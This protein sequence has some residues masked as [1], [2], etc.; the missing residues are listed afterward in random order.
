LKMK[1][2]MAFLLAFLAGGNFF[3]LRG[4]S[5]KEVIKGAIVQSLPRVDSPFLRG[6]GFSGHNVV[7]ANNTPFFCRLFAGGKELG[8]LGPGS[9]AFDQRV[10]QNMPYQQI[11]IAALCFW[12]ENLSS[13]AGAAG[14]IIALYGYGYNQAVQWVIR[15]YDVKSPDGKVFSDLPSP[16]GIVQSRKVRLPRE[17]WNATLGLQVVNNTRFTARIFINGV[18]AGAIDTSGIAHYTAKNLSPYYGRQ[19]NLTVIF[20]N[21]GEVVGTYSETLYVPTYGVWSRQII[22]G[23]E[24]ARRY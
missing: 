20:E 13:Y 24:H 15:T 21:N 12:D 14:Q 10:W 3:P 18:S 1:K 8:T 11:P 17:W 4:Q 2:T 23:P 9:L 16:R 22:L 19:A 7:V 6:L 5:A